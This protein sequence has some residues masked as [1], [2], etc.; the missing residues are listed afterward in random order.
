MFEKIYINDLQHTELNM[1]RC[2][3][4]DCNSGHS[5]G[6][7]IRDHYIIHYVLGGKGIFQIDGNTY[8]LSANDGFLICP[9]SIVFY[10]ADMN[11]PWSYAWVGFNGIKADAYMKQAG[12]SILN[13]VFKYETDAYLKDCLMK[14]ID[15]K[16]I[17]RGREI[18]L[19]GLLYEFLS[20]LIEIAGNKS[21]LQ[22]GINRKEEYIK[23]AL[24]FIQMNY[25][26]KI[27]ISE[28]A[29]YIG[30]DR[31]YLY[32]LFSKYLKVSPQDFLITFRIDKACE[33]MNNKSLSLGDISRSI[34]YEDPL[35]FSKVF[36]K[37][38]G[39]S[40][41]EYRKW[42]LTATICNPNYTLHMP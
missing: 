15:S 33:L 30:L 37:I 14:M 19:L 5:W 39:L 35:Q 40:P 1:Y 36:K 22:T 27:S 17:A 8:T 6:P 34:G 28:M 13:P 31:S 7:A 10:Q 25:S 29:H 24:E 11:E 4:E 42:D 21:I 23:K 32:L 20:K 26:R 16:D 18:K 2:G 3:I 12:L 41:R 38:K 9:N